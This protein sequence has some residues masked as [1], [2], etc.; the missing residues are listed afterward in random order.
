MAIVRKRTWQTKDGAKTAWLVDYR[1]GSGKRR[2]LTYKLKREA[3]AALADVQVEVKKGIHTPARTSITVAEAARLWIETGELNEL[4]RSTIQQRQQHADLHIVPLIGSMKLAKLTRPA[5]E[6][7]CDELLKKGSRVMAAKVLSSL[8]GIIG[9]AGR[10]GLVAQNVAQPVRIS[11][12]NR[13]RKKLTVGRDI[14][15]KQEVNLILTHAAGRWRPFFIAAIFT[16]L[17]A[18]E[19]RGLRW[20]D[21]DFAKQVLNVRQRAN[22][23]QEIGKPKSKAGSRAVPLSP[24]VTNALREWKLACP[25]GEL[26][27]VFPDG[28]GGVDT[29]GSILDR[30]FYA[31]QRKV[32]I[33]DDGKPKYGLHA[34]RH[35]AA[36]HWIEMGFSPKRLQAML[37]HSSIVMT[38]DV[39]G[40]LFPSTEDDQ[41]KMA[42]GE[43]ALLGVG[44]VV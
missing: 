33:V 37:G 29:H 30:G 19:L 40:H 8:K 11:S 27:L 25:K 2:F 23:W 3:E 32:G 15:S 5:I 7:F 6:A 44:K 26:D 31:L 1:D 41:S 24:M 14:P 36:S 22:V 10:R 39:Y 20:A 38:F 28:K 17:R 16:G 21:V 34:L 13:D 43:A 12:K 4:E 35:F 9:E 18:S 42:A